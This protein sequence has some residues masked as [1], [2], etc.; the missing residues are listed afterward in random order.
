MKNTSELR[1]FLI[2]RMEG[3][4]SGKESIAH[5]HAVAALAKQINATLALEL[6]ANRALQSGASRFKALEIE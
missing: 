3:L 6:A 5:S 2:A 4:A 1:K